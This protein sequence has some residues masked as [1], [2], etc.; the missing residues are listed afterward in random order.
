M[1]ETDNAA[2]PRD[3]W[4]TAARDFWDVVTRDYALEPWAAFVLRAGCDALHRAEE[5]L[6]TVNAE[7]PT[8]SSG[9]GMIR[10]HPAVQIERES[11]AA[12]VRACAELRLEVNPE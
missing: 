8:F 10:Q 6:A 2:T 12:F 7:G 3:S 9:A 4:C 11:R 1:A 5:E